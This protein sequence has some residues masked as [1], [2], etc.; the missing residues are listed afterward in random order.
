M[1]II[2]IWDL[3]YWMLCKYKK[4]GFTKKFLESNKYLFLALMTKI[5]F[6]DLIYWILCKYK[7]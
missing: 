5:Y 1:A 4:S 7:I 6:L 3:I 2:Y